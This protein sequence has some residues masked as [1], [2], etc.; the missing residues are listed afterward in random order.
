MFNDILGT[1]LGTENAE[2]YAPVETTAFGDRGAASGAAGALFTG[3]PEVDG[4]GYAFLFRNYRAGLGKWQTADPLGYPDGWNQMAYCGN[5]VLQYFDFMG[6]WKYI[7]MDFAQPMMIDGG[8]VIPE[9]TSTFD[10]LGVTADGYTKLM[11][12]IIDKIR[13]E[14]ADLNAIKSYIYSQI[15]LGCYALNPPTR[16]QIAQRLSV[17]GIQ[18]T[19]FNIINSTIIDFDLDGQVRTSIGVVV[20]SGIET[21]RVRVRYE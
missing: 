16:A 3:K 20:D 10:I 14:D 1:T 13:L 11:K 17:L 2:G 7:T 6:C 4:L 15:A 9:T 19:Q 8:I 12:K 18:Y 21:W 5:D